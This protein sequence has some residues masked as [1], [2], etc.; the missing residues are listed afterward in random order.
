MEEMESLNWQEAS[1]KGRS[2]REIYKL[3]VTR[4]KYYLLLESQTSSD[5][6]HDVMWGK[7]KASKL[8]SQTKM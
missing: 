7:K 2:K 1:I 5:F 8:N 6:I 3:F 4:G